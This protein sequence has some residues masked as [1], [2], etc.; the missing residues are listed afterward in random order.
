LLRTFASPLLRMPIKFLQTKAKYA[1]AAEQRQ[2]R[3]THEQE[4][5]QRRRRRQQNKSER[6]R[7]SFF[8]RGAGRGGVRNE[9]KELKRK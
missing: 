8:M 4:R 3:R 5:R 9:S 2:R 7:V 1:G 6:R